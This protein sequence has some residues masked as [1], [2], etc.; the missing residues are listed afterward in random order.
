MKP[1]ELRRFRDD[2]HALGA[3][4]LRGRTFMVL[5]VSE[6]TEGETWRWVVD[7]L[8][9]G[10]RE[11]GLGYDWVMYSSETINEAG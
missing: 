6:R 2:F 8:R 3:E 5:R 10:K 7:I 11:E 1:G 9:D 4:H